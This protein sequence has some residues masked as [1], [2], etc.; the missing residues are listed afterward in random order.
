VF[1]IYV[2]EVRSFFVLCLIQIRIKEHER[3]ITLPQT[4]KPAVAEHS[5]KHDHIIKLYETKLLSTKTAYMN[6]LIMEAIEVE[7]HPNNNNIEDGL[8]LSKA[9]T[10]LLHR[11]EDSRQL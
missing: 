11:L 5:Y 1:G 9:W 7:L 6:S 8:I 4:D 3:P 10:P 2:V